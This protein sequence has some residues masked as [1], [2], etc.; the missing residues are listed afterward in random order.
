MEYD[1][2]TGI[3]TLDRPYG[4]VSTASSPYMVYR[5]YIT[6]P[7]N[8]NTSYVAPD[9]EFI[10]YWSIRNMYRGYAIQGKSLY[11]TQQWL[12]SIDP[13]RG[14]LNDAYYLAQWG[15]NRQ[16]RVVHELYPHPTYQTTYVA[17]YQIRWPNLSSAQDMPLMPYDI[18]SCVIA[19]AKMLA[20]QWALAN[21]GVSSKLQGT[22]W[23]AAGLAFEGEFKETR[24]Q[25]IKQDDEIAPLLPVWPNNVSIPLGGEFLQSHDLSGF[26]RNG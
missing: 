12:N 18:A 1:S 7:N 3:L 20:A 17:A 25:C 22:N 6:P 14:S 23:V 15:R 16:Q 2:G 8:P 9:A 21:V 5:C 4:E 10:K 24:M 13:Q 19:R 26:V 11:R